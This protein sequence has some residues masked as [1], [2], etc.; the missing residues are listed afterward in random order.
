MPQLLP[1]YFINQLSFTFLVLTTMIYLFV[2]TLSALLCFILP[3]FF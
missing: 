2:F 1:F 3:F